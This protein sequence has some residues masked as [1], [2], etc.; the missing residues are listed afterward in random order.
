MFYVYAKSLAR[1]MKIEEFVVESE[2]K[3]PSVKSI[4]PEQRAH[5]TW[6]IIKLHQYYFLLFMCHPASISRSLHTNM[7]SP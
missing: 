2:E 6:L 3:M 4:K 5:E 7:E 1:R